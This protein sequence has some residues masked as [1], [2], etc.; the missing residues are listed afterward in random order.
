[1]VASNAPHVMIVVA[2]YYKEITDQLI[3]GALAALDKVGASHELYEVP[4]AFEIPAGI[5]M[6]AMECQTG[7]RPRNFDGYVALGCVIRGETTHYE[8]V[9]Q[10]SSRGL[11]NL[12]ITHGL[13]IGYGILTVDDREQ[14]HARADVNGRDKGGEATRACLQLVELK[15][16]L[17]SPS[18]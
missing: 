9:C 17:R 12:A 11:Q 16:A 5:A 10:E 1:M 13:A 8:H 3:S 6:G 4:G 15:H 2:P 7:R 18:S 14:A